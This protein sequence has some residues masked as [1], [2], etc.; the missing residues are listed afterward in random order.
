MPLNF[1]LQ[2]K[3]YDAV[4][5]VVDADEI[6]AYASASGDDNPAYRVGPD[7]V[8]S[9]LFPVVPA[10]PLMAMVTLDPE[11]GLDNPL[12]VV[13]GEH[14]IVHHRPVRPAETLK[15]SAS[16]E[17]VEDK[18]TSA[19]FVIGMRAVTAD[20]EPVNDQFATIL[21][22]GAGSGEAHERS[23]AAET[24]SP[25]RTLASFVSHVDK[26][27]PA[28]YAEASG[29]RN[30]IHLDDDVARAVGLPGVINHGLGTLSLV[31]GGLVNDLASGDPTRIG[32]IGARFT[33]LV[34]PGTDLE[35]TVTETGPG[36]YRFETQSPVGS[37]VMSGHVEVR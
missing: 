35:T 2:G 7:Q 15:L 18:G 32:R 36:A 27:M 10:M 28:R 8:P 33:G 20:G 25:G 3:T 19:V 11:L 14:E 6:A 21:A 22:R 12:M 13:H 17:S 9:P 24:P 29:D 30:P 31:A 26:G 37:A 4:T 16:L 34:I 1:A 5:R 23:P